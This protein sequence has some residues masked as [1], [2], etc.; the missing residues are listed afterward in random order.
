MIDR[1]GFLKFLGLG[2]GAAVAAPIIKPKAF[3]SF[4]GT[5]EVFAPKVVAVTTADMGCEWVAVRTSL[6]SFSTLSLNSGI[7]P[8]YSSVTMVRRSELSGFIAA[9]NSGESGR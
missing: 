5:G 7:L 4:F 8:S 3:F 9:R 1:R 2:A 6:P